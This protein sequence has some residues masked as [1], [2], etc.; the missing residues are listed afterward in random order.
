MSPPGR[1]VSTPGIIAA[2]RPLQLAGIAD[3]R[4]DAIRWV[5]ARFRHQPEYE[6]IREQVRE[7]DRLRSVFCA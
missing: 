6:Q 3:Y 1:P 2:H 7:I 4:A 5:L